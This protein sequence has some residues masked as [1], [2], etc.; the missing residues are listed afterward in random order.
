[1]QYQ[2]LTTA[3]AL[4]AEENDAYGV[5]TFI[6]NPDF[7]NYL[8]WVIT[9]AE[10]RIYREVVPLST[11]MSTANQT[12]VAGSRTIALIGFDPQP[13]VVEG[14]AAITPVATTPAKG[15]RWQYRITS[16]DFIDTIWPQESLTQAPNLG[17]PELYWAMLDSQTI[18]VAPTPDAAY[19]L[20]LTG[21][22]RP[23]P[24]SAQNP[25]TYLSK[26][27]PDLLLHAMMIEVVG[28]HQNYSAEGHDPQQALSWEMKYQTLKA[29]ATEEENRR[30]GSRQGP[31]AL[32]AVA[33]ESKQ[34]GRGQQ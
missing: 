29:S 4:L 19:T 6:N 2:D 1:M 32:P 25:E 23:A 9:N 14:I 12:F 31:S 11:R 21:I 8:P 30:R 24:I 20:E 15:T 26:L 7:Q 27:Y 33:P 16:L 17:F 22:F 28:M 5:Y 13:V 34:P 18:I 3:L 10:Q